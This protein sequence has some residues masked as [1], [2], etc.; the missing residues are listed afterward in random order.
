MLPRQRR[1]DLPSPVA[2]DAAKK[3]SE[4]NAVRQ[5]VKLRRSALFRREAEEEVDFFLGVEALL[6]EEHLPEARQERVAD[7]FG[8]VRGVLERDA[9]VCPAFKNRRF[10]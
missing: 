9:R 2:A 1:V 8:V 7:E 10:L 6:P 4:A 3:F 5:L